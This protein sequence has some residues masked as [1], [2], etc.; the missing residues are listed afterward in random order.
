MRKRQFVVLHVLLNGLPRRRFNLVLD[1]VP[2]EAESPFGV[3][4]SNLTDLDL[5][6]QAP[7][8]F[9]RRAFGGRFFVGRMVDT[10]FVDCQVLRGFHCTS[11][12]QGVW[13]VRRG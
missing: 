4:F 10:S 11:L 5:V 6:E 7:E 9:E 3:D 12:H 8:L 1:L 2:F 13:V